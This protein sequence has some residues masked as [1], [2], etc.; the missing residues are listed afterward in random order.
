MVAAPGLSDV[1]LEL[2]A[3]NVVVGIQM[4]AE[5]CQNPRWILNAME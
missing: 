5:I 3:A 2:I 4:M 1:S